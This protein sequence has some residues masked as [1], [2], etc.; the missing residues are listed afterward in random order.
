MSGSRLPAGAEEIGRDVR[1]A[2]RFLRRTPAFA[3]PAI[4]SL[5]LGIAV[6]TTMFSVVHAVLFRPLGGS[7]TGELIR[8]GRSV[9][10]DGSFRSVSFDELRYLREGASSASD[11][12]GHQ[13]ESVV[14]AGREGAAPV[15]AEAVTANYFT[16]LGVKPTLGRGFAPDDERAAVIVI[17]DRFWR[18]RFAADSSAL[19]T[20]IAL[21]THVF[22][23]VGVAPAGFAGTFPGVDVDVWFPALMSDLVLNRT[24]GTTEPSLLL[25][26]R[27]K[28]GVTLA[29]ARG[30][31]AMLGRR[32]LD[33]DPRRDPDRSFTVASA[34][35]VHPGIA[36][37][38]RVFLFLLMG[39]VG[40]VL[41]IAC[42]NVASMLL[43]R[44]ATR[45]SELA[46]RLACGASRGRIVR[47]LLTES[48]VLAGAGAAAGVLLSVWA[49]RLLDAVALVNGPTGTP[50]F[51][52]IH[53]DTRVLAFTAIVTTLTALAFG[54]VPAVRASRVDVI[55][56]LKGAASNIGRSRVSLRG[57]L[58]VV[59]V[60]LS[61]VLLVAATLLVRSVR[62]SAQ[63]ALGFE[64]DGVVVASFDPQALGYAPAAIAS[65]YDELLRRARALPG[66]ERAALAEN[67]PM[68]GSG[69]VPIR[70]PGSSATGRTMRAPI[71]RVSPDY[72]ATI[73]QP[74]IRGRDFAA[75]DQA[76]GVA[77]VNETLAR[78][79]WP[80]TDAI[81]QRIMTGDNE[82]RVVI[83]VAKNALFASFD[84]EIGPFLF[85]PIRLD[86]RSRL[87]LN[88]RTAGPAGPALADLRRIVHDI[89]ANIAL[90]DPGTMRQ[91]M[92]FRLVPARIAQGVFGIAGAIA[93]LLA[94][95]GLYGLVA[96]ALAQRVKEIGIRVALGAN[97]RNVFRVI[98]GNAFRL[99]TIGVVIGVLL[100][101]V[102]MRLFTSLLYGVSPTDP[103]TFGGIA[104]LLVLVTTI[105][106]YAAARR[107]LRIDPMRVLRND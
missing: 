107:G 36:R 48:F 49:T 42:A 2:I 31:I 24:G 16:T 37:V 67:V 66:A 94:S 104:G 26:A 41:L 91:R 12:L 50:V 60:A 13:V 23:I 88:L 65:F 106:G 98:V 81:G 85:L 20:R 52:D 76:D 35:G 6:N 7:G 97:R 102:A 14:V 5:A 64:P 70:L 74:L 56:A 25:I 61:F 62:N 83:G 34:Q 51:L 100:S 68:I 40:I 39:I 78:R 105:A 103:L 17:S 92:A 86:S 54:L 21:N 27:L 73:R 4:A 29:R 15:S 55:S 84:G 79:L 95:G 30:E 22:S 18:R 9:G 77:I 19:G 53:L 10:G 38:A 8:I 93:L 11:I 57:V 69:N 63:F 3:L 46:I 82:E 75:T 59:Q 80:T 71:N 44:A 89:D 58:V 47:Q 33:Q 99:T 101:A 32:M 43:A 45:R 72:L 28:P 90:H 87:T 1:D 96:Y